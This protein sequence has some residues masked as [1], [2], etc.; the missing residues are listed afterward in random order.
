MAQVL[1]ESP[2]G[3]LLYISGGGGG[4]E[5]D[6][7]DTTNDTTTN[8]NNLVEASRLLQSATLQEGMPNTEA[9]LEALRKEGREGGLYGGGPELAVLANVLRR[10]IAIYEADNDANMDLV[11]M[12]DDDDDDD[13][14]FPITCK[15]VFGDGLFEDPCEK[16]PNSAILSGL[17]PGAYSWRLHI[18]VLD[19]GNGEKHACVLLPQHNIEMKKGKDVATTTASTMP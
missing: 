14:C 9:Y 4:G 6:N 11:D 19:V 15:G 3:T 5:S 13:D 7:N 10:P 8:S 18:L 2:P 12:Q 17:Q 16:I 1:G